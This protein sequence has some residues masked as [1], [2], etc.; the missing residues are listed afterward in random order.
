MD[1]LSNFLNIRGLQCS[2]LLLLLFNDYISFGFLLPDSGLI[3][4][5]LLDTASG[6]L[7][8]TDPPPLMGKWPKT[9]GHSRQSDGDVNGGPVSR[10]GF[11]WDIVASPPV[12]LPSQHWSKIVGEFHLCSPKIS[13]V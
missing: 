10:F 3:R 6:Q 4:F 11:V 1:Y 12:L 13:M 7:S 5:K 2:S 8:C 9:G